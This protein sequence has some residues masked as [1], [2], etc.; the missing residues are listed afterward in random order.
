MAQLDF[1]LNKD[2]RNEFMKFAISVG[3]K[4]VPD[5]HYSTANYLVLETVADFLSYSG[6]SKFFL[7][8]ER[9]SLFPLEVRWFE[10]DGER[11]FYVSQRYGGPAIDFYSPYIRETER[12]IMGHGF[13]AFDPSY[14]L[15]SARVTTSDDLKSIYASFVSFIKK[16][17]KK[18]SLLKR[19]YW[20]GNHTVELV[21]SG[22]RT[23]AS[24]GDFDMTGMVRAL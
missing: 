4:I 12:G 11:K 10:K 8:N 18:I 13:I 21:K 17:A 24:S 16:R 2:E 23:V 15:G 5:I 20:V 7:I 1:I 19:I 9:Y 6:N 3:C 14:Y 22:E